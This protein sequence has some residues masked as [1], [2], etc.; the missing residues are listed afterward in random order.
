MT[1]SIWD[2]QEA[3]YGSGGMVF[4]IEPEPQEIVEEEYDPEPVYVEPIPTY[5]PA[6][7]EP[8][9]T[10]P[11]Y[12]TP[13][14]MVW[15][16]YEPPAPEPIV[17]TIESY[18]P[19]VSPVIEPF[20][21]PTVPVYSQTVVSN[22]TAAPNQVVI[23]P[24]VQ[25]VTINGFT[26]KDLT[27]LEHTDPADPWFHFYW[28]RPGEQ[29]GVS[30]WIY[31]DR[32][33]PN[34]IQPVYVAPVPIAT[35]P[36]TTPVY[37]PMPGTPTTPV[38]TGGTTNVIYTKNPSTYALT[39][40]DTIESLGAAMAAGE[41]PIRSD[42]SPY[43]VTEY[44]GGYLFD[45]VPINVILFGV[46]YTGQQE[47]LNQGG[48]PI[49]GPTAGL[50]TVAQPGATAGLSTTTLALGALALFFLMRR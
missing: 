30:W 8:V 41:I 33:N 36:T 29:I 27:A 15:N 14:P 31:D 16:P 32:N 7:I 48:Q 38:L 35:T 20:T 6:P 46:W 42:G 44:M 11:I 3:N 4:T 9:F 17:Y 39:A 5:M 24:V 40:H 34:F 43:S 2:T 50:P 1:W 19:I 26:S 37:Q 47:A 13:A 12:V 25:S 22:V 28:P 45:G 18:E 49:P 21:S 10:E 23:D